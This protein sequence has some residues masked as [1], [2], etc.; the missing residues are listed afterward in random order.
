[1]VAASKEEGDLSDRVVFYAAAVFPLDEETG[2]K[3]LWD[4]PMVTDGTFM[5]T[6]SEVQKP[7]SSRLI[8]LPLLH[9]NTIPFLRTAQFSS[10]SYIHGVEQQ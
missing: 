5:S 10:F 4:L 8:S 2:R 3:S 9:V 6:A 1:M 7:L